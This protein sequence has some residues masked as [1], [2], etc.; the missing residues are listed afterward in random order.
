MFDN[1]L[2]EMAV[3]EV[4]CNLQHEEYSVYESLIQLREKIKLVCEINRY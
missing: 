1:C 4:G 3:L 2:V